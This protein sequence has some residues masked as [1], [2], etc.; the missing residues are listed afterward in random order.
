MPKRPAVTT[1]TKLM[2]MAKQYQ[3]DDNTLFVAAAKTYDSQAKR[4]KKIEEQIEKDG[5]T[6][7]KEYVKGRQNITAHPLLD[8]LQKLEDSMNRTLH[9]MLEIITEIGE[10]PETPDS[11][12]EFRK[13]G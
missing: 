3:V 2:A 6:V 8:V 13:N 11:L 10:E 9:T 7:E 5:E 4:K 12:T 1:Y